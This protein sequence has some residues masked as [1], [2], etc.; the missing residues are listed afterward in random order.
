MRHKCWP[1]LRST[2][3]LPLLISNDNVVDYYEPETKNK[4]NRVVEEKNILKAGMRQKSRILENLQEL[5]KQTTW[6][7]KWIQKKEK[8][9][10][11]QEQ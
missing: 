4:Q 3:H 6:T 1:T 9:V 5:T 10:K 11:E 2:V 8:V 7:D